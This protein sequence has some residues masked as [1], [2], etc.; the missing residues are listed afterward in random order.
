MGFFNKSYDLGEKVAELTPVEISE[1]EFNNTRIDR[2]G[3]AINA[4]QVEKRQ[5][6]LDCTKWWVKIR[7]KYNLI[8]KRLTYE[9]GCLYA[10]DNEKNGFEL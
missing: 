4:L 10:P 7:N 2:V 8:Q 9:D 5:V 1:H 3:H 6:E